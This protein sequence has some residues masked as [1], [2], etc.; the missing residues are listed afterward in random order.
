MIIELNKVT[1]LI[2]EE[3][4]HYCLYISVNKLLKGLWL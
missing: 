3:F 2:I 1:I 4:D